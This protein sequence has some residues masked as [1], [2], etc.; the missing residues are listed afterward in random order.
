[1]TQVYDDDVVA[2]AQEQA[3]L[4]R[5]GQWLRLDVEHLAEEIEDVGKS[6]KRALVHRLA[7]LVEHLYKWQAQPERRGNSWLTTIRLQR[8]QVQRLLARMPSLRAM[9]ADN[10]VWIGVWDDA[11]LL[12]VKETAIA[13]IPPRC[14]WTLQQVLTADWLP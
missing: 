10:D 1:M 6:E 13:D 12:L 2:W 3:Q 8:L 9:M 11:V 4:L 5:N 14:P 7:V